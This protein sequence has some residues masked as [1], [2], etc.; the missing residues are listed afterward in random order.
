MAASSCAIS[1]KEE[2]VEDTVEDGDVEKDGPA[3]VEVTTE[4]A[5]ACM[6]QSLKGGWCPSLSVFAFF[7]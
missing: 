1:S 6:K 5:V 2:A 7:L 3:D 4:E